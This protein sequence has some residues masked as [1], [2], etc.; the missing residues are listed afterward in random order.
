MYYISAFSK[1]LK[2]RG[3]LRIDGDKVTM[4]LPSKTKDATFFNT[5]AEAEKAIE[6]V[7][8]GIITHCDILAR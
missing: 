2:Q 7:C 5:V 8:N 3:P 4:L 6:K 1:P